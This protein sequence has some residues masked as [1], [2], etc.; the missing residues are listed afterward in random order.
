MTTTALLAHCAL[1]GVTVTVTPKGD[2]LRVRGPKDA[3]AELKPLVLKHRGEVL[4]LLKSPSLP[5][6]ASTTTRT[7]TSTTARPMAPIGWGYDWA[8]TLVDLRGLRPGEDGRPQ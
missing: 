7:T 6:T 8:G 1:L 2:E 3:R 5:G 4:A